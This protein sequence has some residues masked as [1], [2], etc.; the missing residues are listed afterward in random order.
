ML[1]VLP[2][3]PTHFLP[4]PD[5]SNPFNKINMLDASPSGPVNADPA[6]KEVR[7]GHPAAV[8]STTLH[9][10]G[11]EDAHVETQ[12]EHLK[13]NQVNAAYDYAKHL[14]PREKMMQ[15]WADFLELQLRLAKMPKANTA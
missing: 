10:Q 12:L 13:R 14:R 3:E 8:A 5:L 4:H 6:K 11:Y 2:E 9:E 1:I 15:D 7:C